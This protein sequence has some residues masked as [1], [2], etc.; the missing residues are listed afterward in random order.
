MALMLG[1]EWYLYYYYSSADVPFALDKLLSLHQTLA[2]LPGWKHTLC[3]IKMRSTYSFDD[4]CA[5]H[6]DVSTYCQ[7][8][9]TACK[10]SCMYA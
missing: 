8:C 5:T 3:M 10:K 6:T 1:H 2:L 4:C 7:A 9:C